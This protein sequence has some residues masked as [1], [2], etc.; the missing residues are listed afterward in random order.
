MQYMI[1]AALVAFG[2]QWFVI[3]SMDLVMTRRKRILWIQLYM[4]LKTMAAAFF[5]YYANIVYP[6]EPVW[7]AVF[8]LSDIVLLVGVYAFFVYTFGDDP[9]LVLGF[10][11]ITEGLAIMCMMLICVVNRLEGRNPF[12]IMGPLELLDVLMPVLCIGTFYLLCP[13]LRKLLHYIVGIYRP[14]RALQIAVFLS[15]MLYSRLPT[16]LDKNLGNS[17]GIIIV[18][19]ILA[20]LAA[21]VWLIWSDIRTQRQEKRLLNMQFALL[22]RRTYLTARISG[23]AERVRTEISRQMEQL[24][25]AMDRKSGIDSKM[26][27]AYIERLETLRFEKRRG[28]YCSDVLVDEILAQIHEESER[29]GME[30]KI[31]LQG[32]DL[33]GVRE[34]DVVQIL[35]DLWSGCD[36]ESGQVGILITTEGKCLVIRYEANSIALNRARKSVLRNIIRLY[37]GRMRIKK[38]KG[39][40]CVEVCLK[41]PNA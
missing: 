19:D 41:P 9:V 33:Q 11:P 38:T 23:E 13:L 2:N 22:E 6:E 1:R 35:Y 10:H 8:Y 21:A 16:I 15:F 4:V 28:I 20:V 36:A 27:G 37:G 3:Y 30:T 12:E 18:L 24:Q 31:H 5:S 40:K 25:E 34:E 32:Y 26:L 7:T 39:R 14:H 17:W 29:N